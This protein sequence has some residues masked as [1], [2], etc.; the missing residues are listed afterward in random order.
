MQEQMTAMEQEVTREV[1]SLVYDKRQTSDSS[2][3][4]LTIDNKQ[5]KPVQNSSYG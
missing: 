2:W 5:T 4:F 3:V 1:I